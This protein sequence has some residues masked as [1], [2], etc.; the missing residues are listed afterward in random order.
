MEK[1]DDNARV[2]LSESR[3]TNMELALIYLDHLI[4]YTSAAT[5][6]PPKV[7]LMD[8]HRSHMQDDF[9]IKAID[10]NIH[11]YPFPG[12]LTYILQ[13]LDV[14]VFQPYKHWHK[15]AVQHT[16]HNLD[17]DYNVASFLC[18]LQE[19]C[20][21]TF[22][23]GTIQGAFRKARMWPISCNTAIKKMKIYAPPE[24]Y[25]EHELLTLPIVPTTPK[26]YSQAEQGLQY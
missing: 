10:H 15:K 14:G 3:Y 4:L 12:H 11:P 13:P 22:K 21:E 20:A 17:I 18:D 8:R 5:N 23:K 26:H 7:L 2:L 1:L 6:K 9:I 19:I 24:V 16:M 25:E